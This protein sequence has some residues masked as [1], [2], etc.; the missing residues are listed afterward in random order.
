MDKAFAARDL[1][2]LAGL[3]HWLKGAAG[4]VGYDAFTEPS[5]ELEQRIKDGELVHI[6]ASLRLLRRL[7]SRIV[8]PDEIAP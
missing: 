6:E 5:A 1:E 8:E 2:E 7:Q 4:T 3:A